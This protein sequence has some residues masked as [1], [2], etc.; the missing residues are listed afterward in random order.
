MNPNIFETD[1]AKKA[2]PRHIYKRIKIQN[3]T[4]FYYFPVD[5]S[6]G[7]FLRRAYLKYPSLCKDEN[8]LQWTPNTFYLSGSRI[9][10]SAAWKAAHPT[11]QIILIGLG[12]GTSQA[13]E[14]DW[15]PAWPN[16]YGQIIS[17]GTD[18][19]LW[20]TYDPYMHQ[21]PRLLIEF[22][23]NANYLQR[24]PEPVYMDAIGTPASDRVIL[25]E[26]PRPVDQD[27]YGLNFNTPNPPTVAATLNFLYKYGDIITIRITGQKQDASAYLNPIWTPNFVDLFLLGYYCPSGTLINA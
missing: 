11:I 12:D 23:D 9:T 2:F 7:Y 4:E 3:T 17:D 19:I 1:P 21:C 6:S 8:L 13:N 16:I 18:P 14:P 26:A 24:Q 10:P 20:T 22:I 5:Y 25:T 27:G 15:L